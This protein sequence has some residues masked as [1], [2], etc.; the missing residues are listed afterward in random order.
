M[1]MVRREELF[2]KDLRLIGDAACV[3]D[4]LSPTQVLRSPQIQP[5]NDDAANQSR[6]V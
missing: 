3:T 4:R 1:Q 6:T 5:V 2:E